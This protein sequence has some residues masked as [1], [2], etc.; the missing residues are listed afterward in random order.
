MIATLRRNVVF[1]QH[2]L[3]CD[4]IFNEFQLV[5]CRNVAIYFD[6]PLRTRVYSLLHGS[7]TPFGI[8][9]TGKKE[10]LRFTGVEQSYRELVSG[11]RVYRRTH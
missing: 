5:L 11:L 2:N 4:G 3:V 1:A 9:V 6:Q 10:T 8:L 7:L